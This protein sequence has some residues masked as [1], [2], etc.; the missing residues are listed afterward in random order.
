V[1]TALDTV[2]T[3]GSPD[4]SAPPARRPRRGRRIAVTVIL[5]LAVVAIAGGWLGWRALRA[6]AA[7]LEAK[8]AT[9]AVR[10]ALVEG[11]V[12]AARTHLDAVRRSTREA[13]D[14]TSDPVWRAAELVPRGGKTLTTVRGLAAQA[15]ALAVRV[16]PHFVEIAA[17]TDGGKLRNGDRVDLLVLE[18]M[19]AELRTVT[20]ELAIVAAD[21]ERLPASDLH[22]TV[23]EARTTLAAEVADLATTTTRLRDATAVAPAMLGA[24]GVRRY[25]LALQTSAEMRGSG[26]LLGGYG[27]IEA[28]RGKLTL[29]A[30]GPNKALVNTYP[31]PAARLGAEFAARYG[32]FGADGF[33]L[34]SNMSAH[35]PTSSAIWTAM[36]ERTTGVPLDGSIAI[37]ASA[38]AEILSATGPARL[39]SG[40]LVTADNV[41]PLTAA[42]IYARYP[43]HRQDRDRDALQLQ[44]ARAMYEQVI[45]PVSHDTGLLPRVGAAAAAGH[46]RMA[47]NHP[48][49]QQVLA[50]TTVGAALPGRPGPYLQLALNNAGGT[51][52]DYYLRNSVEYSFDGPDGDRQGV[53]VTVKLRSN[54]PPTGLP[55]YVAV[56]PDLPGN[57]SDVPGQNRLWVSV[58][59][60]PGATLR[61][62]GLDGQP[63]D[64]ETGVEQEHP[65]FSTFV[66][67]DP[68][69]ERTLVLSLTEPGSGREVTIV[70]P[71]TVVPAT[72]SVLGGVRR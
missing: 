17:A 4:D 18:R 52:L 29:T 14:L 41:V 51:K 53:S 13:R 47:S 15:D 19:A 68:G 20:A 62:A 48:E 65:V 6:R 10:A 60:G 11:D 59:A 22:A 46:V 42:E 55:S 7:L 24:T 38:M 36:Y 5:L 23:A 58:Y 27:I 61:G 35:F 54:A 8:S 21:I 66:T 69:Q 40:E 28:D 26:G 63:V 44:I 49:E 57:A 71:P 70:T 72:V 3:A 37:D 56:R 50:A 39:P 30:L 33:W 34:N 64:I 1:T 67:V 32:R 45:A 16:L 2:P 9:V 12:T 31:Q 43:L 25:F